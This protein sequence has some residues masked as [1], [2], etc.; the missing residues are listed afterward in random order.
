MKL[1]ASLQRVGIVKLVAIAPLALKRPTL[2]VDEDEL[3][4]RFL[5]RLDA[6]ALVVNVSDAH[7][8]DSATCDWLVVFEF[9]CE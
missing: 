3:A 8:I 7:C 4:R 6:S 5:G 1:L 2:R 9:D